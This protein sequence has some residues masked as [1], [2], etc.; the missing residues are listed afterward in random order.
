LSP[1]PTVPLAL[2]SV[3]GLLR[4]LEASA[5]VAWCAHAFVSAIV[6]LT[7]FA[8]WARPIPFSLKAAVLCIGLVMVSP[9]IL[10]YDLCILSVA[11]A[12]L[13]SDGIARGFL[14][15]ERTA[16]LICFA[17]LF[18]V[19]VPIGPVVCAALLLL[20]TRRIGA[21]H[22]LDHPAA[23]AADNFEMKALAGD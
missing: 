4:W 21:Y 16:I 12:F 22:R 13:V 19:Q 10:F 18:L 8:V 3:F 5:P 23:A 7:V 20:A 2:H 9:Y 17:A 11:V 6:A 1:D 15:G 14:P